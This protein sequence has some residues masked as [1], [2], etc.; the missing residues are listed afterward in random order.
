MSARRRPADGPGPRRRRSRRP[1]RGSHAEARR[2][3]RRA[4]ARLYLSLHRADPARRRSCGSPARTGSARLLGRGHRPRRRCAALRLTV[5]GAAARGPDQRRAGHADRLGAGPR[6]LPRQARRRRADRPAVRAADDRRRPGAARALRTAAARSASTWPTPAPACVVALLFVTLPFVVRTVQPVLLELD[7][8]M[9]QAAAS[10]G[11]GTLTI[12]RR[13]VLPNLCPAISAGTALSF[14]RA[15]SE[16]GSTVLISGNIP[17]KTQ[18][19]VGHIFGQIESD[20]T[21]RRGR[22]GHRA[23]G[24]RPDR[25]GQRSTCCSAGRR[26]VAKVRR[27]VLRRARLP[28]LPARR[29]PVGL[30]FWRTFEHGIGPVWRLAHASPT[31]AARLPASRPIVAFWAVLLQHG[32]R[33][34]RRRS[35]SS[36]TGSRAGG[37]STRSST[38]RSPCRRSSSGSP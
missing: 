1:A 17:F 29:C 4:R 12:F 3:G 35:C 18:V 14:A 15:I 9:E 6:R 13:I 36:A 2:L 38:C 31:R 16:F 5:V 22:G 33:G 11:A 20:N 24:H 32:L 30:V 23:A 19:A 25:A 7:R 37:C 10:L 21:D 28:A 27:C 26:A 8:E 34:R